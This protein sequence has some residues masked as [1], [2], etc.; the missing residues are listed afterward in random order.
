[1][2]D[3]QAMN[4]L[5]QK[6]PYRFFKGP[7]G[8]DSLEPYQYE[9]IQNIADYDKVAI[10]A[11][12]SISKTWTMG[13]IALWFLNCF[14]ESIVI[15]TAPTHRQVE[16]L[17]WG[18]IADAWKK[19]AYPLG[20]HLTATKLKISEKWYAMGFSPKKEA[21][22]S[23]EQQ[24]SSFQ[25]FHSK[26]VMIIFDEATGIPPDI[27]KMAQGLLTSGVIV[28]WVCIANPTTRS[29]QFFDCFSAADWFTMKLDCFDSPNLKANGITNLHK[30]TREYDRLKGMSKKTRLKRIKDYKKPVPYLLSCQ[31]VMERALEWGID[32]PLFISKA[33]GEFPED[34]DDVI[35]P[36][37]SVEAAQSR[38]VQYDERYGIRYFG[39][40]VAR[41]GEDATVFT[42]F[43]DYKQVAKKEI[44]KRDTVAVSGEVIACLKDSEHYE[45]D[46]VLTIDETGVGAGVV[47]ILNQAQR[48]GVIG[49]HIDIHGLHFGAACE[50]EDDKD[51][52]ANLKAK[53]FWDL[54][55]DLKENLEIL[56]DPIYFSELTGIL[57]MYTPAG[58][59][60]IESKDKY[61]E[62]TGK[63]SPDHSDSMAIANHGR[64]LHGHFGKFTNKKNPTTAFRKQSQAK[65]SAYKRFKIKD[66]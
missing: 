51:L 49:K 47:D 38:K 1:M 44:R 32:H 11:T 21:G 58:K 45:R 20:G 9:M 37:S 31:W 46:T 33:L 6:E 7:L 15:T 28:K 64:Y 50:D 55:K 53:I 56:D 19:S 17:L 40:D 48:D 65:S 66:R 63:N 23:K 8:V 61:K 41:F 18:E 16:T 39:V 14:E 35:I 5:A 59:I 52:F 54:A 12:H 10:R 4:A 24:G 25:G 36:W 2:D 27:W 22:A 62:R 29:C 34:E 26:Y 30:L 3:F 43:V 60:Q 13:R 57:Y 42:D